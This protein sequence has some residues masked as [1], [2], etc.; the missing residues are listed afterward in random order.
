M[1]RNRWFSLLVWSVPRQ[2]AG[3]DLFR[4]VLGGVLLWG[5]A[6]YATLNIELPAGRLSIRR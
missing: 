5:A 1:R 6:Q 3:E 2:G 4:K